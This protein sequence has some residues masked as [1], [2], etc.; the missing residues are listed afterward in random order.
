M[1]NVNRLHAMFKQASNKYDSNT[2]QDF[3]P[4]IIDDFLYDAQ[5]DYLNIV[6]GTNSRKGYKLGLETDQ[7]RSDMLQPFKVETT[8][9]RTTLKDRKGQFIN[10]FN[11]PKDYYSVL[12]DVYAVTDCGKEISIDFVETQ[13]LQNH[14][15]VK[16]QLLWNQAYAVLENNKIK[17]YYPKKIQ[18]IEFLY[19]K[20]PPKTFL[21]GYDTLEY[22]NGN[23]SFPDSNTQPINSI[24][25]EAYCHIL[26]DIAVQNV[27]LN[28]RDYNLANQKNQNLTI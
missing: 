4:A 13:N 25:P 20:L 18:K 3:P 1:C 8:L 14:L 19:V 2:Y 11:L 27:F 9:N 15:D 24:V 26:I 5:L 17:V 6:T 12:Q 21:G 7:F 10:V 16:S 23:N 22:L 28:L